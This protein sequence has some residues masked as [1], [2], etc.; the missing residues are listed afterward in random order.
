MEQKNSFGFIQNGKIFRK[1][2]LNYPDREIGE[3]RGSEEETVK[4]FENRFLLAKSK[5]ENL[6][7]AIEESENKGSYLMKL[8][9]LREKLANF[10]ALGDYEILFQKLDKQEENLRTIITDNRAKNLEIK[11][12][13]IAEAEPYEHSSDWKEAFEKLKE[14]KTKWIKTGNVDEDQHEAIESRFNGIM[15]S[16]FERRNEFFLQKKN[17]IRDR[18]A[19]YERV[20]SQMQIY[21]NR[22]DKSAA[23]NEVKQLQVEW[24]SL[25]PIPMKTKKF[26]FKRFQ[27]LGN[28]F[29]RELKNERS[30]GNS[31]EDSIQI[32]QRIIEKAQKLANDDEGDSI[33]EV[34]RLK[35]EWKNSG[36]VPKDK[37]R[38]LTINFN[39]ACDLA[40]EKSFLNR[41]AKAKHQSFDQKE[42]K[43][44]LEIKIEILNN[45][46]VRD[47]RELNII[48]ENSE[49][50][51]KPA[52]LD[53]QLSDKIKIQQRKVM[54]KKTLLLE[55]KG[56]LR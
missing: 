14:I 12:A 23:V 35:Y 31:P 24:K 7:V 56:K 2:F 27:M 16:F 47:E 1:G 34:K 51:N 10:D 50:F 4:Y 5:V 48:L 20:V 25:G 21:V 6:E 9:H 46:L 52:Y 22:A 36:M 54:V 37:A 26:L 42:E 30:G 11:Q 43:E 45:L 3:V 17:M 13:L 44:K 41:I 40:I 29:F 53:K 18:V 19:K 49:K 32:K 38:E 55:L 15:N 33:E 28:I 39:K 8:I